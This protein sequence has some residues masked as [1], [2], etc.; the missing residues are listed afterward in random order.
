MSSRSDIIAIEAVS[1]VAAADSEDDSFFHR[2]PS[3]VEAWQRQDRDN[4]PVLRRS[5]SMDGNW[6]PAVRDLHMLS[7]SFLFV[8]LAYGAIQNLESSLHVTDGLGSTSLALLYLSLTISSLGSPFMVMWLGSK[9]AILFGLSGY[10]AFIAANIF[11]SWYTM[12]P[13]SLFLGFT[14]SILW[15]AEGTYLTFAAKSHAA[16]CNITE[17]TAIGTFNGQ[18][19]GVFASNQVPCLTLSTK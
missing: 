15:V 3:V 11:P 4:V 5:D 17:A 1:E 8:F 9:N 12:I 18:F 19:W 14:A 16:A 2:S 13:A 10:W 7:L 6:S